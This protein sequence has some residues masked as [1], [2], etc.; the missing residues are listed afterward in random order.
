[1][2]VSTNGGEELKA[3]YET[4]R[5]YHSYSLDQTLDL[6]KNP[7]A[8]PE[9]VKPPI[10]ESKST[11]GKRKASA[12]KHQYREHDDHEFGHNGDRATGADFFENEDRDVVDELEALLEGNMLLHLN[13]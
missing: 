3:A 13:I 7:P 6:I 8:R 4:A 1:M 9:P 2:E 5:E 10:Q 12:K 11:L